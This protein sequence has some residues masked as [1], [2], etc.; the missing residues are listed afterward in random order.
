MEVNSFQIML[1]DVTLW[2]YHVRKAVL[3]VVIIKWKRIY[4]AP[5]VKGLN[6]AERDK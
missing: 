4:A 2:I 1:I 5:A 6:K 3:N